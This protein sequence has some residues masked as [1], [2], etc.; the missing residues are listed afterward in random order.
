MP[1]WCTTDDVY[2]ELGLIQGPNFS[3]PDIEKQ[4]E[5]SVDDMILILS[6]KVSSDITST[7]DIDAQNVPPGITSLCAKHAAAKVLARFIS[8]QSVA[9][10]ATLAGS[11]YREYKDGIAGINQDTVFLQKSPTEPERL[12]TLKDKIESTETED[13]RQFTNDS[14]RNF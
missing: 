11:L 3:A 2:A 7:W 8:G 9:D 14:L 1:L 13:H 12:S 5:K 4:I 10:F 6:G